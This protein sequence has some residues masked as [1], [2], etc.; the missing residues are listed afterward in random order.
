[1]TFAPSLFSLNSSSCEDGAAKKVLESFMD[2]VDSKLGAVTSMEVAIIAHGV[3]H[4]R[5]WPFV[6]LSSFQQRASTARK[7]SGA[8][9]VH[10]N[11][12][13][14]EDQKDEWEVFVLGKNDSYWM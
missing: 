3:D 8:L 12:M 2:I 11:P 9:Y 4:V 7:Q 13:V 10:I 5:T 6:T 1:M 14:T